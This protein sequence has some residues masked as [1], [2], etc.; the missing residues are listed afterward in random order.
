MKRGI[1]ITDAKGE[2]NSKT[3]S[4][5]R[6]NCNTQISQKVRIGKY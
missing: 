2:K 5:K 3:G 4:K 6:R 1:I